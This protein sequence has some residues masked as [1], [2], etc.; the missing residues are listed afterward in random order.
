[1]EPQRST[2]VNGRMTR[3]AVVVGL[4]IAALLGAPA[5]AAGQSPGTDSVTGS[6]RDCVSVFGLDPCDRTILFNVD[7]E[8]GPMGEHPTGTV[9]WNELGLTPGGSTSARAE[10]TCLSVSGRVAI[11]GVTGFWERFGV[12]GF[13][14]QFTGLVRVVDGGGPNSAADTIQTAYEHGGPVL[15]PGPPPP[16]LPG[17]TTC[18]SFPGPFPTGPRPPFFFPAV[19]TNEVGDVSVTDASPPP[20]SKQQCKN[21]GW[22]SFGVFKN[23]GDCVSFVA[24]KGKNPARARRSSR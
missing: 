16:P 1:M 4:A 3:L 10:A 5:G 23:Q 2:L 7:V 6:A 14:L 9:T 8:S 24:T 13:G 17:P 20:S 12:G 15:P 19:F 21:G 18:S 22:R 11:I